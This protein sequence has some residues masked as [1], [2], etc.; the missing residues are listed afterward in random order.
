MKCPRCKTENEEQREF[1]TNCGE[2]LSLTGSNPKA[3]KKKSSGCRFYFACIGGIVIIL[4]GI[5]FILMTQMTFG[6]WAVDKILSLIGGIACILFGI[7]TMY[8]WAK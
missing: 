5:L 2:N 1:C 3:T 4:I 6:D 8:K 7:F